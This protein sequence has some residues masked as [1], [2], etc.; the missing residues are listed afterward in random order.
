[1]GSLG[2]SRYGRTIYLPAQRDAHAIPLRRRRLTNP[3]CLGA[4]DPPETV[5]GSARLQRAAPT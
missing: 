1:M 5:V 2:E 3:R 4:R